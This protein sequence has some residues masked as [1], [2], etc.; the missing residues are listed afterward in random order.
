[1]PNS[2]P[3]SSESGIPLDAEQVGF[4]FADSFSVLEGFVR[5]KL[6]GDPRCD[7]VVHDILQETYLSAWKEIHRFRWQSQ[8]QTLAWLREIAKNKAI[9]W[10]RKPKPA[11]ELRLV[12]SP[13][14]SSAEPAPTIEP[15]TSDTPSRVAARAEA[16]AAMSAA[17][18]Q[19]DAQWRIAIE[20]KH[21]EGLTRQA[22]A[23]KMNT[24]P[25]AVRGYLQR[26]RE[27]L[28]AILGRASLYLSSS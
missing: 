26:G 9:D 11:H 20:L 19:L 14:R 15:C 6:R 27:K 22:I 24:T 12:S 21:Y 5:C 16:R 2:S 10:L 7:D 18:T 13:D 1:M 17:L 4:L 25:H 23:K 3:E 8:E 28:R